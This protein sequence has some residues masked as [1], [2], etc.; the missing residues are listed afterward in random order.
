MALKLL[1][2]L[3]FVLS[4]PVLLSAQRIDI[5]LDKGWQTVG[6]DSNK[7]AFTGFESSGFDDNQWAKVNVPHNWD[8]YE[9]YRRL[10]HG[11]RHGFAWYRKSF[12][13]KKA[14]E[15]KRYFL[16][17]EGVG[18]Y[19]T[20]WL[21][22][23]QVGYHAG[24]R[25]TF[26][27]DVT[28]VITFDKTNLLAVRA[29]HPEN[30]RDLPWVCG[31]C[32]D[33]RG[34]SE[35]SQP[36]G[37]FRPVHLLITDP[38]RIEPFGV[39]VWN[40]SSATAR[41]AR[42]YIETEL[43]NYGTTEQTIG[44][45][46][47]LIDK[48]GKVVFTQTSSSKLLPGAAAII[49]QE[50]S[51]INDPRLWSVE[52]P[53]LYKLVSSVTVNGSIT[54]R[55]ET[56]YGIR[57]ISWPV[58]RA[59]SS[60]QFLLNGKPVFINGIAEYEHLLGG[61]HAFT[62]EQVKTRVAQMKAAGF[63][64]FRDAHHPHNLRYQDYWDNLGFLWWTQMGAHVWFDNP[65]FRTNFKTLLTEWVRERRNSPSVVLW[66]L[67]NESKLPDDF[68]RECTELIRKLDPTTSSQR[69]V[70]TCN[71]GTGTD[72]DV[73]QNWTGTYGGDPATYS[74]DVKRQILIGEYGAWRTLDLHTEGG[75]VQ[76]GPY[77]EDRMTEL[78]ETKVRLAE[79]AKDS[80]TGHYM[81]LL[82]SHDNPGRVQGGE[83]YRE[84]DRLGPVNY[85]GL[86]TPWEEPLDV[87]Y[88]YRANYAPKTT[89]PMV[90]I[91]SHTWPDRWIKPGVRDSIKVYSNCDEVELFNDVKTISLG[92]KKRG[93]IGTH[94]QWDGVPVNYNV[95]YAVGYVN[96]KAVA[97]DHI[98][99]NHLPKPAN[100]VRLY[101]GTQSITAPQKGY[102]YLYR[103]NCGGP[104][105][106]DA[107][108]NTWLADRAKTSGSWGSESWTADFKN[109][110]AFFASQRSTNDPINNTAD[111]KLF[112][113]FRF[114]RDKL[115]FSFPVP[116]G[117]YLVELYFVEPWFGTGGGMDC[118]GWR[119]FDVA[120]NDKT[121][122]RK[123]DIFR[124]AGHDGAL[125]K[126]VKAS[127]KGGELVISFPSVASGQAIISAI[128]IASLNKQL[129]PAQ[130]APSIISNLRQPG[131]AATPFVTRSWMNTGD[132][133]YLDKDV[134]FSALPATMHGAEWLQVPAAATATNDTIA[135]FTVT[136]NAEV[137]VALPPG[138][139]PVWLKGWEDTHTFLGNNSGD[140][141]NVWKKRYGAGE[142]VVLQPTGVN[143]AARQMYTVAVTAASA[144]EPAY[145]LKPVISY[146]A[147]GAQ[148]SGPG[149]VKGQVD[150]KDRVIFR[151]A[152]PANRLEWEILTGVGDTYSLTIA[153]NNPGTTD[154]TGK[155]EFF[156]A[157]GTLMKEEM[158]T[159]T[160]TRPGKSN[161]IS[162]TT[163]SMIN[164]GTYRVRITSADA[165][166]LSFNSLDVQ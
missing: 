166:G 138:T 62:A 161:Y 63:N 31:G 83:G 118:T 8:A 127:V 130:P 3:L 2:P 45:Q 54:D 144:I 162:T 52:D 153:Y 82:T 98:V 49:R 68:A 102:H 57:T 46:S 149:V 103:V 43:K 110:P 86:L 28:D 64:S 105:Y 15:G 150:G 135:H 113:S 147:I 89:S 69:L 47:Q 92:R 87:Y 59:P 24:G 1:L 117:E 36:M 152:S 106:T 73:P 97:E 41:N 4:F 121:A 42:L 160:P 154:I 139:K 16:F 125:K 78:M 159:F 7:N 131:R 18:S 11:N 20:V 25:T 94:F 60:N 40:D 77:S 112:Q 155:L 26:T 14:A 122:I 61:S 85:K 115:R 146:K 74:E 48:A 93:G 9:G 100:F 30:I 35:G 19:A 22:G 75:F 132:Q 109:M 151:E 56:P 95:L 76:N 124:E 120:V 71:G 96:G 116:D 126:T 21:N 163:G 6:N 81:W 145:D 72:W 53:Y 44:L 67:Q 108:G 134:L 158:I 136:A 5:S 137:L 65:A 66:G 37:I 104:D 50:P 143:S 34:F 148:L 157:D 123:L 29:D 133:Q 140:Q 164:A 10:R 33:E 111:W 38:V 165:K 80:T 90:Y 101:K 99:L 58:G 17:F 39:H 27:I 128:A 88:M 141:F 156:S 12:N 91:A 142:T 55:L 84:L 119:L 13:T 107:R 79:A 114:G 51:T 23:K 70:T 32:S 129:K